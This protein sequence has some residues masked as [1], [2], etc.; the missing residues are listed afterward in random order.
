MAQHLGAHG[1]LEPF[2]V[3]TPYTWVLLITRSSYL[4]TP[5]T[6]G[7]GIRWSNL[8][9]LLVVSS[10]VVLDLPKIKEVLTSVMRTKKKFGDKIFQFFPIQ[11]IVRKRLVQRPKDGV[12]CR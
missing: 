9:Y 12:I 8:R 6:Y 3:G 11:K 1:V 4:G 10:L 5:H 7:P 2:Y